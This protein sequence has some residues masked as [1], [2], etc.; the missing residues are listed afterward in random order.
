M[1]NILIATVAGLALVGCTAEAEKEATDATAG[2][3][4]T[5]EVSTE[6]G[7]EGAD[8]TEGEEGSTGDAA[9]IPAQP[10]RYGIDGPDLD[11]CGGVGEVTGLD[12][13][14]DNFLAVRAAPDAN[15]AES[16]RLDAGQSVSFCDSA[17]DDS[18]IGV[19]YDKSGE[20][21]CGTGSPIAATKPY[22]GPCKAGWV[23]AKYVK[24]IAG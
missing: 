21:D 5:E 7:D 4:E 24:L 12:P 9:A 10:V 8:A 14:G 3:N 2:A 16:D 18:W 20:A 13:N 15:A 6:A 11:S 19:V 23:S 17:K 1:R 22:D